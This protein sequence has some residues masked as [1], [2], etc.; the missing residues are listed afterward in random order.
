M[1]LIRLVA[2]SISN[3]ARNFALVLFLGAM[4]SACGETP[5]ADSWQFDSTRPLNEAPLK[6]PMNTRLSEKGPNESYDGAEIAS[7]QTFSAG[8]THRIRW[9]ARPAAGKTA[10]T[11]FS[12]FNEHS[13][14]SEIT[15]EAFGGGANGSTEKYQ[16]QYITQQDGGTKQHLKLHSS[17][18]IFDGGLHTFEIHFTPYDGSRDAAIVWY[19][20]GT[21]IRE[22]NGGDANLLGSVMRIHSAV[23]KVR[24]DG[25]W[26]AD[27]DAPLAD[28]T[29]VTVNWID[30]AIEGGDAWNPQESWLFGSEDDLSGWRVSN[31]TFGSFDGQYTYSNAQV[32]D[33]ALRLMLTQANTDA[34]HCTLTEGI[35]YGLENAKSGRFVDAVEKGSTER[36]A[37]QQYGSEAIGSHRQFIAIKKDEFWA[38]QRKDTA[39]L[40]DIKGGTDATGNGPRVHLY[41]DL[42]A[43]NQHFSVV[44]GQNGGCELQP[45]H[46]TGKCLGVLGGATKNGAALVQWACNDSADQEWH[47]IAR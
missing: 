10:I 35:A 12:L 38:L 23:W 26:G 18:N 13:P 20:D 30:W 4:N 24:N 1:M 16:T 36:T 39:L 2:N 31:W 11:L 47:F 19:I 44:E 29:E 45:R 17:P 40:A 14:W 28:A 43:S 33:S 41:R 25:G 6:Q 5:E 32:R 42:N 34:N 37:L 9:R 46:A 22:V 8:A 21:K 3:P 7:E 15:F 27:G